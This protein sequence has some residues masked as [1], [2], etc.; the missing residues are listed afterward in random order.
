MN[1]RGCV[2]ARTVVEE[3]LRATP[4]PPPLSAVGDTS[5]LCA[6]HRRALQSIGLAGAPPP[7]AFCRRHEFQWR[8]TVPHPSTCA[9]KPYLES[10]R[11]VLVLVGIWRTVLALV[12]GVGEQPD[13]HRS[14]TSGQFGVD[15]A[16]LWVLRSLWGRC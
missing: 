14:T 7:P 8:R 4:V 9:I 6:G 12:L 10:F 15:N 13:Y 16:A 3:R 2:Q 1:V 11:L 5:Q